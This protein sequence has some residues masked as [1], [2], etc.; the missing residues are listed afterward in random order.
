MAVVTERIRQ[1]AG[2]A[3]DMTSGRADPADGVPGPV[4]DTETE[5]GAVVG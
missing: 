1:T 3:P 4:A 5:A 2:M